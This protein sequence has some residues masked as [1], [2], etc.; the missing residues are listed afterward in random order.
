LINRHQVDIASVLDAEHLAALDLIPADLLEMTDAAQTRRK[1]KE[2]AATSP[3][4]TLPTSVSIVDHFVDGFEGHTLMVRLYTPEA[5]QPGGP[6]L[7]W[8]HGGGLVLGEV[9]D[10]DPWCTEIAEELNLVVA[11]V[12]YRVAPEFTY[13][14]PLEDCYAGLAWF[15]GQAASLGIDSSRIAIAGA[16]AGGGL[17]AAMAMLARDRQQVSPCFQLLTSPMLDDRNET[18]SSH[19]ITDTRLW[20]REANRAAWNAYLGGNA[21][22]DDVPAYAAPG[23]ATDLSGLPP[24]IITVGDF[25]LFVDENIVFAQAL[26]QA[27]VPVELHV[28]PGAV[29]GTKGIVPESDIAR[30]W[31]RD[32]TAALDRA[33]NQRA[34]Q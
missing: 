21:G 1:V 14:I 13:P 4:P 33:L 24:A 5:A 32:E 22:A 15:F 2:F 26:L 9:A 31:K 6:G 8:V 19:L 34:A 30:R 28:Y 3:T 16:S 25:D 11:S 18:R 7:Y 29:H 17:A 27:G 20:N 10:S 23:R 12:E